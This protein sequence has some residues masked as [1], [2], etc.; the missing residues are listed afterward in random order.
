MWINKKL[1]VVGGPYTSY[2]ANGNVSQTTIKAVRKDDL[3]KL[4]CNAA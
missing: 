1:K 3:I 2:L 4:V